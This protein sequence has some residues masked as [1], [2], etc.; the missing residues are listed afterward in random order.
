VKNLY[1]KNYESQKKEIQEDIRRW[2]DI[3]CSW[4][5]RISVVK[6]L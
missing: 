4:S 1:N 6:W 2:K 5:S 3:P